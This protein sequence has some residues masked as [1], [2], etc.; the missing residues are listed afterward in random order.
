M[1]SFAP[2]L[3]VPGGSEASFGVAVDRPGADKTGGTGLA[4]HWSRRAFDMSSTSGVGAAANVGP[5]L[6][7]GTSEASIR[8][9]VQDAIWPLPTKKHTQDSK[10][11]PAKCAQIG[12]TGSFPLT[13]S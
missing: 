2:S 10:I 4:D 7:T 12:L 1:R 5:L 13:G 6:A 3:N 8:D 11:V 9:V